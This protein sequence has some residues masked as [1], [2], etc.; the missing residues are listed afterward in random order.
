MAPPKKTGKSRLPEGARG[1]VV[2]FDENLGRGIL[3]L[4]TGERIRFTHRDL[5]QAEGFQVLFEGE[6]VEI[7]QGKIHRLSPPQV[8]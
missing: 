6:R 4:D 7:R 1:L 8:P 5:A 3:R 2:F